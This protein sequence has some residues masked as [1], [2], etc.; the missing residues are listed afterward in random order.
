MSRSRGRSGTRRAPLLLVVLSALTMMLIALPLVAQAAEDVYTQR[1]LDLARRLECPVCNGQTVADSHSGTAREM[2]NVIEQKVAAGE[3]D[4]QIIAYFV[5]R[6]G[7]EI[8][9]EPPKSGFTLT[10]WWAPVG[11][12]VFGLVIV[13]LFLR[14]RTAR[15]AAAAATSGGGAALDPELERLARETLAATDPGTD[16]HAADTRTTGAKRADRR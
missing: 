11:M 5:E 14:E 9:A 4:E 6:F 3:T 1:T 7:E 16:T 8:L 15:T 2:R 13:L 12:V 10:L